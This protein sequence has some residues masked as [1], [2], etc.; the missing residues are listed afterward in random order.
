MWEI[1]DKLGGGIKQELWGGRRID[2]RLTVFCRLVSRT[3][4]T[5]RAER[6]EARASACRGLGIQHIILPLR[7]EATMLREATSPSPSR[8]AIA[9]SQ[10]ATARR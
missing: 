1:L 7:A 8:L 10:P 3:A 5:P 2:D 6:A 9:H 4:V